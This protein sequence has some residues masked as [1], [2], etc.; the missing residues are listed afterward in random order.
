[1]SRNNFLG[2]YQS[3]LAKVNYKILKVDRID[4]GVK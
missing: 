3:K 1:M 4:S 2:A